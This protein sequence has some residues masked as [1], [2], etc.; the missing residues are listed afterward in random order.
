MSKSNE[1]R[2]R[3]CLASNQV[4]I[5]GTGN[6]GNLV[7]HGLLVKGVHVQGFI[8]L[9]P[10]NVGSVISGIPVIDT[11][12]IPE[13]S[14]VVLASN[15]NNI[16]FLK[17]TLDKSKASSFDNCDFL[18]D[19][20]DY[21][22]I[23]T[24]WSIEMC[25]EE[26]DL[27]M[28]SIHNQYNDIDQDPGG[29]ADNLRIKSLDVV[30]T[31]KCNL[32]CVDCSN[33]MQYYK[34]P[35]NT[36]HLVLLESINTFMR[37]VDYVH[38][39]RIIGGE[40]FVYR[41]IDKVMEL[42]L[43]YDNFGK[44]VIYT[45]GTVVP[46]EN[47]LALSVD[48]RVSFLISDYGAALSNRSKQLASVLEERKVKYIRERIISW[49]DCAAIDKKNRSSDETYEVFSNCCAKDT[50]SLLHGKVYGCPFSAHADNLG[51]IPK[52]EDDVVDLQAADSKSI[53]NK[54]KLMVSGTQ[55]FGA[56]L[57]CNGRDYTV[58]TVPA[59]VQTKTTLDYEKIQ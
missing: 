59:A 51:A 57:F 15:R 22:G 18:F 34:E 29:K 14:H 13:G 25:K 45:N 12:S 19:D 58:S 31:E 55:Y 5:F 53:S 47:V 52:F 6:F 39:L 32:K 4:F 37:H 40:P 11:L 38:E 9:N 36:E 21:V 20:F 54:L 23:D 44:I 24:D 8:D 33:L 27:F 28:F 43:G 7:L 16:P 49:H 48:S 41:D 10:N 2:I 17:K 26:I 3:E 1:D 42:L 30:L 46:R 56:C 50:L 35:K